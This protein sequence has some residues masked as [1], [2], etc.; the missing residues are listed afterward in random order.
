MKTQS[1]KLASF[2]LAGM[3]FLVSCAS[4]AHVEKAKGTDLSKYK[5]YGWVE[6]EK[7]VNGKVERSKEITDQNIRSAVDEQLQKS[8]WKLTENNPDV[9]VSTDLVIEKNR[10]QSTDPVYSRPF[11][12]SY[13]NRYS[14]RFNSFYYPSQF[15]GYDRYSTTIKEGTVTVT[16]IDTKTDKAVWQGWATNELS[17]NN[18]SDKEISKNVQSI[19]KKFDANN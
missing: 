5:S 16:M 3:L 9:L 11:T 17:R 8:G 12:R 2:V 10:K 7:A 6:P 19:F 1:F 15:M 14:G 18:I 13:Y 4:T